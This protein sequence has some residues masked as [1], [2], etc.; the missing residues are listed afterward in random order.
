VAICDTLLCI[1]AFDVKFLAKPTRALDLSRRLG[2]AGHIH[3]FQPF[4]YSTRECQVVDD[5]KFGKR[6]DLV[7]SASFS[8]ADWDCQARVFTGGLL[9]VEF[10]DFFLVSCGLSTFSSDCFQLTNVFN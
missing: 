7:K 8:D 1:L 3:S 6:D 5:E 10:R 9:R 4:P 2:R